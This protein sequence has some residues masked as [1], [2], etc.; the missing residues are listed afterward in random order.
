MRPIPPTLAS[1]GL[2]VL[3]V[4]TARSPTPAATVRVVSPAAAENVE[5]DTSRSPRF[6]SHRVQFLFPASDFAGLPEAGRLITAFNFRA[7]RT[8]TQPSA[9]DFGDE[10]IWMSTTSLSSLTSVFDDNHGADRLLVHDGPMSYPLLAAG[11]GP[12]PADF[13]AGMPLQTPFHYDPSLGNLLVD[14]VV[15]AN[16][17][18]GSVASVDRQ[19]TPEVR[20]IV[21]D[22]PNA[23]AGGPSNSAPVIQFQFIPEPPTFTLAGFALACLGMWRWNRGRKLRCLPLGIRPGLNL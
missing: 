19:S 16:S 18:S 22:D 20:I 9:L 2:G 3:L 11:P 15:F 6:I 7:D 23:T 13:A 1:L 12:G 5:G 8:Q 14:R 21:I 17:S 10:R 4:V